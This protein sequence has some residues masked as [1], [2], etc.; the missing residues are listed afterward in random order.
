MDDSEKIT[1]NFTDFS[2]WSQKSKLRQLCGE[3]FGTDQYWY[4][5]LYHTKIDIIL[6]AE[7]Q[8]KLVGFTLIQKN[9]GCVKQTRQ[10]VECKS[11]LS[12]W[13]I[14][15]ICGGNEPRL[16]IKMLDAIKSNAADNMVNVI[17][18]AAIQDKVTYYANQGFV[19]GLECSTNPELKEA[20]AKLQSYYKG[21]RENK[22][23]N[24]DDDPPGW[25]DIVES[26]MSMENL[27]KGGCPVDFDE[28][29]QSDAE[30]GI[31]MIHCLNPSNDCASTRK[32][33]STR[34]KNHTLVKLSKTVT[35]RRR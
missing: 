33:K 23:G 2:E 29:T 28:K 14:H 30:D 19:I 1:F 26:G 20:V 25:R 18:L 10:P 6:T 24:T 4:N 31:Y 3:N 5:L 13:Y 35:P 16:G 32:R 27:K 8:G 17:S 9:Y 21:Q 34:D 11:V 22:T 12:T 7:K 15:L